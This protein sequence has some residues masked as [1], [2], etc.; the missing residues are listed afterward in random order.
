MVD[1]WLLI[2]TQISLACRAP[3]KCHGI[4]QQGP[5]CPT[6]MG[7]CRI[8]LV[9]VCQCQSCSFVSA[10]RHRAINS[11]T[12]GR[13]LLFS[14]HQEKWTALLD[15]TA[16]LVH[17]VYLR[18]A[19]RWLWTKSLRLCTWDALCSWPGV[20][21]NPRVCTASPFPEE[22]PPHRRCG[23]QAVSPCSA[24]CGSSWCLWPNSRGHASAR[25]GPWRGTCQ[26]EGKNA[27]LQLISTSGLIITKQGLPVGPELSQAGISAS[28]A[29]GPRPPTSVCAEHFT[30]TT[31]GQAE[32]PLVMAGL[33]PGCFRWKVMGFK[34]GLTKCPV[35]PPFLINGPV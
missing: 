26:E 14:P 8:T 11:S 6:S 20:F 30:I 19:L 23:G 31:S 13:H 35:L 18:T 9:W 17:H 25:A 24:W 16:Q 12:C 5:M 32:V 27:P 15:C 10:G 7:S 1:E 22:T 4:G 2:T 28:L 21:I 34:I 29:V 3:N 33:G